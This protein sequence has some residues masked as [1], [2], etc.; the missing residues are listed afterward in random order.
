MQQPSSRRQFET[1]K[2]KR[3]KDP[4]TAGESLSGGHHSGGHGQGAPK[5][6][7][8]R[9]F[10]EL[11]REFWKL[12]AGNRRTIV[13]ALCTLTVATLL[14]LA[15][16]AAIK[17]AVDTVLD[18]DAPL[19][20]ELFGYALP[21][22]RPTL[23]VMLGG[24]VLLTAATATLIHLWGRWWATRSVNLL[25]VSLRKR[26]FEHTLRLPLNRIFD[27]KTG[28]ATSLIR[29]DTGGAADLVF[30]MLYNPWRAIVQ[31]IGSLIILIIVDWRL[32][33]G[34]MLLLPVVYVT[35][36]TWIHRI[37][38]L[39]RDV[40]AQRQQIDATA[41]E[42]FGGMRIVRA[43]A[44]EKLEAARFVRGNNLL[45]RQQLFVWLWTRTIEVIWELVIPAAS[46]VL[47]LYG[48]YQILQGEMTLGEL[49]MFLFYLAM[50]LG[51]LATLVASAATFQNNLAG[52]DR[53][54]DVLEEDAEM[55]D[56]PE[57]VTVAASAVE[58]AISVR[59]VD[60]H[61]PGASQLVLR[62]VSLDV[63]PGECVALVGRSG[64]GKTTLCNLIA[65]FYDPIEGGV[66]L[67]G[68]DIRDIRVESYRQL[69]GVVEQ[70]VFLFDGTIRDNIAYG[71]RGVDDDDVLAAAIAANAHEFVSKL[72]DGYDSIIG[73]RGVKLSGGQ[74]QRLAIARAL[75][76][77]PKILIL[78]EATSN[79]DSESEALIQ[80][81]LARL[82]EGR[83]CFVIAHRMSTIGLADRIAVLSEGE[84]VAVAPHEELLATNEDYRRM[85]E[86]QT[87]PTGVS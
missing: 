54:L 68:C 76:A 7:R 18:K 84:L 34:G 81:S 70:D 52:L 38:P 87:L 22:D 63:A 86:L 60:F 74:R 25:Q 41:T 75:L 13:F 78:D 11:L 26:L 45:V 6:P 16:P 85:V 62:N 69:L 82:M 55:S 83:T 21:Q 35:H 39:W 64:A 1:Y 30:S 24:G 29:E 14:K 56:R 50:L 12:L 53:I 2:E 65:R 80:A 47:L 77:D 59:G 4:S 46:T 72:D 36:R 27:L 51:P 3:R 37:R 8:Q 42:A 23:L 20:A 57:S 73:E 28:G 79:L 71:R 10:R 58:G 9:G 44:R 17:V 19:P 67:D 32:M 5:G 66:L 49:T 43:F 31:L 33:L 40:R 61:Y 15:P 48:G